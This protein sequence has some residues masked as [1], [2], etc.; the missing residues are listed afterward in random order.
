MKF[1]PLKNLLMFL[2][3]ALEYYLSEY[4]IELQAVKVHEHSCISM[5]EVQS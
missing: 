4:L 1:K 2:I 5:F 3:N